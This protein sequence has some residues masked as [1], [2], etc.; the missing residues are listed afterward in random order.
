VSAPA[1]ERHRTDVRHAS[2]ASAVGRGR[3]VD[4]VAPPLLAVLAL[5]TGSRW[6]DATGSGILPVLQALVPAASVPSWGVLLATALTRRWRL[7]A[8]AGVLA[9][10]HIGLLVPW[11]TRRRHTTI[12]DGG[13]RLVVL[14]SNLQ[15]G[16]GDPAALVETVKVRD[17]DLLLLVEVTLEMRAALLEAGIAGLLPHVSGMPGADTD[18]AMIFSRHPLREPDV[19]PLPPIRY[20]SALSTAE[21]PFGDVVAAVVHPVVPVPVPGP[22]RAWHRELSGLAAWAASV[23]RDMPVVLA[24]DFNATMDHPVLRRLGDVGIV[25]AHRE[26]GR[27]RRATWPRIP[28]L[29]LLSPWFHLDHVQARGFHVV[30]ADTLVMPGSDHLAVW[31]ELARVH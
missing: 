24:G 26:I 12:R 31:A 17:V 30:D 15:L 28:G 27:G 6:A 10:V 1:D 2:D 11:V 23:P 13:D 4:T 8:A 29:S 25:D 5:V 22:A 21:T 20:G 19:A 3:L 14:S 9:A 7:A 18:T 16:R